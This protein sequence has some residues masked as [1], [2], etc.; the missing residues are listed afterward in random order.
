MGNGIHVYSVLTGKDEKAMNGQSF[1]E[2]RR[3]NENKK[4]ENLAS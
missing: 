1:N 3:M 4:H 2:N